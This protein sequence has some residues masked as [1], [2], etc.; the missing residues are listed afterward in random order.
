MISLITYLEATGL[1]LLGVL[2]TLWSQFI[3]LLP[4]LIGAIILLLIGYF[5][6]ALFEAI[7]KGAFQKA[8]LDHWVEKHEKHHS[9]GHMSACSILGAATK[10]YIFVLFLTEAA[11]LI[12]LGSLSAWLLRLAAWLPDLIAG[13]LIFYFGL[14]LADIAFDWIVDHKY[15]RANLWGNAAKVIIILFVADIAL[16][17]IG[18]HIFIAEVT[19]MI[20]LGG[21][22]LGL[23][24]ALGIGFGAVFKDNA[25]GWLKKWN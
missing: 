8:G 4:G 7:V 9:L 22:V 21:I 5:L 14:I 15:K 23:A 20:V 25:K 10:W 16:R 19:Y 18:I 6:G 17:Q 12:K 1:S 13:V 2:S 11:R 3:E 24:I